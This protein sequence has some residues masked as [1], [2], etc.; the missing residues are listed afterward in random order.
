MPTESAAS[1]LRALGQYFEDAKGELGKV[2]WPTPKEIKATS[3]AVLALVVIMSFFFGI[4]DVLL[5]KIMETILSRG[6]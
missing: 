6:L 5:A 1:G 3:V 4:V 2:S